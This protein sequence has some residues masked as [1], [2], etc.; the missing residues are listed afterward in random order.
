MKKLTF[1]VINFFHS[2]NV[3]NNWK[4][5]S[6][7]WHGM[8]KGK[9][10]CDNFGGEQYYPNFLHPCDEAKLQKV[11][12]ERAACRGGGGRNGGYDGGRGGRRQ[13]EHKNWSNDKTDG[14]RND[15]GNGV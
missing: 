12:E 6:N 4:N 3:S 10:P 5:T 2:L 8:A 9:G 15:N 13:G 14:D 11:K 1:L 7:H